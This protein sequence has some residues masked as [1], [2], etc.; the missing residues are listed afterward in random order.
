LVTN[1]SNNYGPYQFPE[2]LIP[3]MIIT[4]LNEKPLP[5]YGDGS[6]IRDWLYVGDHCGAIMTVLEKGRV[7]ETYAIG[8]GA[9]RTNLQIVH[10]ICDILDE[11]HPRREGS[12]R[13]LVAFVK[14]RP[15]HDFRYAIDSGKLRR[16]LGWST[17]RTFEDGISE[18]VRWYLSNTAWTERILSGEYRLARIGIGSADG[19]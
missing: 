7:G 1:C 4:A 13:D 8:G 2:K 11:L 14:D 3:H 19:R 15:G 12:Y 9:E 6:N 16:E 10:G 17:T 5:V 18:T